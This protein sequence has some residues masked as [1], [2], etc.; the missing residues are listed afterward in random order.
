MHTNN[1]NLYVM[2][3]I[4]AL[5]LAMMVTS[6]AT[7]FAQQGYKVD[8]EGLNKKIAKSD[9]AIADLKKSEKAST[10]VDRGD[11]FIKVA[12]APVAGLYKNQ[13]IVTAGVLFGKTQK[14]KEKIGDVEYVTNKFSYFK[15]YSKP[16]GNI[17]F[18][19]Q[20]K[21]VDK[22]ALRKATDAFYKA[23]ELDNKNSK[24]KKGLGEVVNLY[25]TDADNFFSMR[26]YAD[27]SGA[28]AKAYELQLH[29]SIMV[30]DTNSVYNAGL[31]ATFAGKYDDGLKYLT[32]AYKLDDFNNGDTYYYM[33]YCYFGQKKYKEAKDILFEGLSKFPDNKDI[34][35][36]LLN[37]YIQSGE[38][39]SEIIPIVKKAVD[40]APKNP[41]LWGGLG[42]IYD[43]LKQPSDAVE[44]FEQVV[45]LA[46]KD[47]DNN[48]NLGLLYTKKGDALNKEINSKSFPSQKEYDAALNEV[49]DVYQQAIPS[50]EKA[51]ELRPNNLA[52]VE[53]L[54]NICFRVRDREGMKEKYDKYQA[55]FDQLQGSAQ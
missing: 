47:A 53:L 49:K 8:E 54:K 26:R 1:K 21:F 25:K 45:K 33:Y 28:F 35:E 15:V 5:S 34:V 3:R 12:E 43:A 37:V 44:A 27:A 46:P 32:E 23:Y 13:D 29:P 20:T 50:L 14:G 4:I 19:D 2:K 40:A 48:Y 36:G 51:L 22:N 16:N 7:L 30:I 55:L 10:W 6:A 52:T 18:W 24:V 42:R 38:D 17:E 31:L 41:V 39:P 9:A 11:L